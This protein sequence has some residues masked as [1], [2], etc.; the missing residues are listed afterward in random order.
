MTTNRRLAALAPM[1]NE[2]SPEQRHAVWLWVSSDVPNFESLSQLKGTGKVVGNLHATLA[3]V[4][5]SHR[6][7]PS[8]HPSDCT[9]KWVQCNERTV[10]AMLAL[11]GFNVEGLDV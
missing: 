6:G 11:H 4:R 7:W 5:R 8:T 2:L 10:L 1:F 3:I 9:W